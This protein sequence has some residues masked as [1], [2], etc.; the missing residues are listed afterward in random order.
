[1]NYILLYSRTADLNVPTAKRSD[2]QLDAGWFFT[3]TVSATRDMRNIRAGA[4]TEVC[5]RDVGDLAL[6]YHE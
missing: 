5:L 1:M 4:T 3:K 2:K 6:R